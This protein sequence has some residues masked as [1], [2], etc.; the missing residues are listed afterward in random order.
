MIRRI[1]LSGYLD[2]ANAFDDA[3][4]CR[5]RSPR[6]SSSRRF[7]TSPHRSNATTGAC[8]S[9]LQQATTAFPGNRVREAVVSPGLFLADADYSALTMNVVSADA[10]SDCHNFR[11]HFRAE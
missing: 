9:S 5:A 8:L 11:L 4:L 6:V 3:A 2:C 1:G 10:P 7:M